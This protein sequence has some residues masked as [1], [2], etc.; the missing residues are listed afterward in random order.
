MSR[1][2]VNELYGKDFI[3]ILT[4]KS[5][6]LFSMMKRLETEVFGPITLKP[7]LKT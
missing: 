7:A 3:E 5:I 6:S 4:M 2:H 1:K